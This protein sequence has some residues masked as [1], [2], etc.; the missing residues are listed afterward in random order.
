MSPPERNRGSRKACIA[1]VSPFLDKSYGTERIIIE[2]IAQLSPA[3]EICIYS[4]QVED[5]DLSKLTW[6]RVPKLPGPHLF[7]FLWWF[8][9]NHLWRF[10]DCRFR[11]MRHDLVFSPGVNCLDADV[12]SVHIVFAE[13]WRRVKSELKLAR[14][15]LRSWPRLLHRRLYYQLV[16][17]LESRVFSNPRTQLILT[18]ARSAAELREFYERY[19][20]FPVVCGGIDCRVFNPARRAGLREEARRTLGL[21]PERFTLLL[22]GNDWL[23]KGIRVLLDGLGRLRDLPIDLI[24]VGRDD[25]SVFQPMVLEKGLR[26]RVRFLPPRKDVEFYYAG[27]DLYTGPSLEDTFALPVAEAMACGLP[28]IA[29]A[30][31]GASDFITNEFNGLILEDPTDASTMAL[32]VRRM[33]ENKEFRERLAENAA[34]AMQ[35]FTWES[36]GRELT[37]IFEDIVRQKK[38]QV[39]SPIVAQA[40]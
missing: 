19:D 40:P 32:L 34:V 2:W 13:F 6:R 10:W 1:L 36:N 31:A 8:A 7:N 3:F 35:Q 23:K 39:Q 27:A 22:I 25:P 4:Q 24:V 11:G 9:A 33:F 30:R 16:I 14:N 15:P 29:S 21:G 12:V 26:E 17:L 37:K 5:V 20:H 18:S 28:V 38:T